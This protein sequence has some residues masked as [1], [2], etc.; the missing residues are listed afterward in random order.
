MTRA[1]AQRTVPARLLGDA[2]KTAIQ[3][4]LER[5]PIA[6][7]QVAELVNGAGVD[8]WRSGARLFGY[9]PRGHLES[10][11]WFGANLIPVAAGPD[12]V[13]AFAA[14]ARAERRRCSS[15]VG[16]AD[17]VL[18]MWSRMQSWWGPA[19][20][21][22]A[23]QPL[24]LADSVPEPP[25]DPRVRLVRHQ[26]IDTLLPAA[27][28]MYTAEVGVSPV[29]DPGS[30]TYRRRV[31]ELIAGRRA[32]ARIEDGE[33][34]FKADLAV[35]TPETAQIQGVWVPPERRGQGLAT[36]G[37]AA[38]VADALR[39][40]IPTVSLYVNEHNTA[41]R[42]VYQRCGFREIGRFATVLF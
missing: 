13:A 3:A 24:L 32:Y 2:D 10:L 30:A 36:A 12:A 17:A 20:Q 38:V 22:R 41:A 35:I 28:A 42:R 33:V 21:V 31:L 27:I 40:G 29:T 37:V 39:R 26:E 9:G 7:A 23:D 15:M 18:A 34:V 25:P 6:G 16:P 14:V 11:C 4:V 5:E 1:G 8:W 19:R